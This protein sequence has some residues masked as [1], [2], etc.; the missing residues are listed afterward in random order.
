MFSHREVKPSQYFISFSIGP[1]LLV[2][3]S[4]PT[5]SVNQWAIAPY[6]GLQVTLLVPYI[7]GPGQHKHAAA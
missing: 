4:N 2:H 7:I 5:C 1:A 3:M 6:A